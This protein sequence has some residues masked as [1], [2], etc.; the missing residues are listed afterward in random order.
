MTPSTTGKAELTLTQINILQICKLTLGMII[1]TSYRQARTTIPSPSPWQQTRNIVP[2]FNRKTPLS[3][4]P[5]ANPWRPINYLSSRVPEQPRQRSGSG[6]ISVVTTS[7]STTEPTTLRRHNPR[8]HL[9]G[10]AVKVTAKGS[11]NYR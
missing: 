11:T 9:S 2:S 1:P 5:R 6:D 10:A 3:A 4:N 7:T 8:D